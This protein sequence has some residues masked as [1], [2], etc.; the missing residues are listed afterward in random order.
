[1]SKD[2]GPAPLSGRERDVAAL[3]AEGLPDKEIA[4]RL[5]LSP[6]TVEGHLQQIR[7]KLGL[8]NRSQIA[9]WMTRQ[10]MGSEPAAGDH[11]V[12]ANNLPV[13]LTSFIGRERELRETTQRLMGT[14]LLTITGP[15]GCGKTR[16]AIQ[17][18]GGLLHRYPAGVWFVD[19]TAV[20][21]H[22][23]V[24]RAVASVLGISEVDDAATLE[25]IAAELRSNRGGGLTLVVLDN[26]EHVIDGAAATADA[27]LRAHRD[28]SF[29][30]TGREPLHVTGE[31]VS[32]LGPLSLPDPDSPVSAA[33]VVSSDA[34]ELF[35]N[36]VSLSD[37]DFILDDVNAAEVA[38]LCRRLDGIP[39][40][41]ELAAARVGLMPFYHLVRHL[42][43]HIR[44]FDR[45]GSPDRQKTL[46]ATFGWSYD[47]LTDPERRLMRM[48]SVFSGGFTFEA[49]EAVCAS[50]REPRDAG[51]AGLLA[52]L[53]DKSL[54]VPLPPRKDR[55]RCL[56]IV[57]QHAWELL[58]DSGDLDETYRLYTEYFLHL[59]E[60][61]G[62]KLGGPNQTF[63][64]DRLASDHDNV[65]TA[66]ALSH[67]ETLVRRL[68]LI[69]A[70]DRFWQVRG[71]VSEGREFAENVLESIDGE[72]PTPLLARAL[73]VA[74][75]LAWD[76][77]DTARAQMW[78]RRSL[79]I[80]HNLGDRWGVQFCLG[81]L[82]VIACAQLDWET[83]RSAFAESLTIA[84]AMV[85]E[86]ATGLALCNLGLVVAYLGEYDSAN[87]Y[88]S[89]ALLI[90][91]RLEDRVRVAMVLAN[92]GMAALYEGHNDQAAL[93]YR[94][95]LR[96]LQEL[97]A[98][99]HLA[100][101]LE[102]MACLAARRG[103]PERAL[104]LAAAGASIRETIGAV[105]S[106]FTQR[107]LDDWLG[108]ARTSLGEAAARAWEEG[109]GLSEDAALALAIADPAV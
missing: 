51:I 106:P 25:A 24:P 30:C 100:E 10:A 75:G 105:H 18:A 59:V 74:A 93:R 91:E 72:A 41:L 65:R 36:R 76:Q 44:N 4:K 33:N 28:L 52:V 45:F 71:H 39:L 67:G 89:E 19:L 54:I 58:R 49:T 95:C 5:Y 20:G 108:Q 17:A 82:A 88:L 94:E 92:L 42:D 103:S 101:S 9:T 84:R 77:G 98:R 8:D 62:A 69:V 6:R 43:A 64:L 14:R 1:M 16:L 102:G 81:N 34:V 35:L 63:W 80:W 55:F 99:Q 12:P 26:C 38:Q 104:R 97:G 56:E 37:P 50:P 21:D 85:N 73:N 48:L 47:L 32:R 3:V 60:D 90:M 46:S 11:R 78:L 107:L 27:L 22:N 70:L 66:L 2:Y 86:S 13:Q 61:A 40:A 87:T 83:A 96:I 109:A 29:L 7:N 23:G 53:V 79:A 15:G 57:R 31:I 68:G